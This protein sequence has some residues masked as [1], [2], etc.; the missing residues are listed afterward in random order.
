MEFNR[1]PRV[2]HGF[3]RLN[4]TSISVPREVSVGDHQ[5]L[6]LK[7][8]V[9]LE[10]QQDI[11]NNSNL[12][13]IIGNYTILFNDD[14]IP[15]EYNPRASAIHT[16]KAGYSNKFENPDGDGD[17]IS[18]SYNFQPPVTCL[19]KIPLDKIDQ[20]LSSKGTIFI[21]IDKVKKMNDSYKINTIYGV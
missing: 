16:E 20:F 21:Y 11:Q 4:E 9:L 6:S 7:S 13:L 3:D 14:Y 17:A 2:V 5:N 15:Y 8:A 19:D 10:T 18:K 12:K 1:L